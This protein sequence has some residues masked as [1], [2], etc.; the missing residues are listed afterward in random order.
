[1]GRTS[2]T[3]MTDANK[4]QAYIAGKRLVG[5]SNLDYFYT[6]KYKLATMFDYIEIFDN[7]S[8][9]LTDNQYQGN[10]VSFE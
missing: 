10:F 4:S 1:M 9:M 3:E 5:A 8:V 2:I 6:S 7:G